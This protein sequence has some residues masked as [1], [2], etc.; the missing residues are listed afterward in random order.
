MSQAGGSSST[1]DPDNIGLQVDVRATARETILVFVM[2]LAPIGLAAILVTIGV[3]AVASWQ[4]MHG[5]PIKFPAS[6]N[7]RSYGMLAYAA[8]CWIDVAAV[9]LWSSRRGLS[10]EVF[11]FHRLTWPSM[12]ASFAGLGIALYGIPLATRWLSHVT[13]GQGPNVR[14]DFHNP[15]SVAIYLF[16]FVATAPICEEILY[17]G[18]LVAWLRRIGW[19]NSIIWLLGS[20]IFAAN[21]LI[22]LGFVWATA[23]IGLGAILF[24]L[25]LRYES[26]IPG[27][28]AHLLFNAQPFLILPFTSWV[29]PTL[30]PG[31]LT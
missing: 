2:V 29:A 26:L 5:F 6:T 24:A 20:L 16:L 28:L 23:M 27:W 7:V 13:G 17:R 14:I 25:R 21:H 8:A 1:I 12:M 9:W 18:L 3:L 15:Q 19:R 10:R 30:L 4:A 22:P 31:Y 11:P